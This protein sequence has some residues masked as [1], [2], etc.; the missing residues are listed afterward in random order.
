[1]QAGINVPM[2]LLYLLMMLGAGL[3]L[4]EGDKNN[5]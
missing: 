1:M 3:L 5:D 2:I 4:I